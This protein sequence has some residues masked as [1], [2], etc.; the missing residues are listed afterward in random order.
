MQFT[1]QGLTNFYGRFCNDSTHNKPM[2]ITETSA[3]YNPSN[4]AG[5][6]DFAIKQNWWQQVFNVQGDSTNVRTCT[7][8]F[9]MQRLDVPD[10]ARLFSKTMQS[11]VHCKLMGTSWLESLK[12][13]CQLRGYLVHSSSCL[14]LMSAGH[15]FGQSFAWNAAHSPPAHCSLLVWHAGGGHQRELSPHQGHHVV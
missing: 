5:S 13:S 1:G 2:V 9:S 6:T 8:E 12:T 3:M 15:Q 14:L 10:D 7:T 11:A 4:S